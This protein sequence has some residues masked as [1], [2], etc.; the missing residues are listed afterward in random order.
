MALSSVFNRLADDLADAVAPLAAHFSGPR[1]AAVAE[2][3]DLAFYDVPRSG[4]PKRL[5]SAPGVRLRGEL[6]LPESALLARTLTFPAATRDY[7]DPVI[8][9]RLDRLTP[10]AP[11]R[12]VYGYRVDDAPDGQITVRF[13]ATSSD[14]VERWTAKAHAVDFEPT[15]LG[16]AADPLEDPVAV[17]LWRGGRD[18]VRQRARRVAGGLAITAFAVAFPL[19]AFSFFA[20]HQAE[21]RLAAVEARA[22]AARVTIARASG[23]G[24]REQALIGAKRPQTA[25]MTLIDKLATAMP[26]GSVLRELEIDA[27]RVRLAGA[28]DAAPE[29]IGALEASGALEG[30]RFAAPVTRNAEGRDSFE[31]VGRRV[32]APAGDPPR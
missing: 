23:G 3:D 24:A 31:I 5:T 14:I 10:W 4:A 11:A 29:L 1:R 7:L 22:T 32:G 28:T 21:A 12:V 2:G 8:E 9:N 20:L 27:E 19:A 25:A 18:P 26:D 16:S 15:A 13:L 30:A 6:R 17:D